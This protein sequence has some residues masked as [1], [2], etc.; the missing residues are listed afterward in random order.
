MGYLKIVV[1][2]LAIII[3]MYHLFTNKLMTEK[4]KIFFN[5]FLLCFFILFLIFRL[6]D[7]I[8]TI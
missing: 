5:K 7:I 3:G 6:I 1:Y 2:S 4:R 8:K